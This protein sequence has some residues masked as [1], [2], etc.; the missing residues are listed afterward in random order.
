MTDLFD[1]MALSQNQL[2][3]GPGGN[4]SACL[5]KNHPLQD[6]PSTK[7]T[8]T[9]T[10]IQVG[11]NENDSGTPNV[12]ISYGLVVGNHSL[13]ERLFNLSNSCCVLIAPTLRV[14]VPGP[15]P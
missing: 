11:E 14:C 10:K 4:G 15:R 7:T 13:R 5:V 8:A 9:P 12:I 3:G 1:G 2:L 6:L